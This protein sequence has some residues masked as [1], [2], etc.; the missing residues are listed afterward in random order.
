RAG[1]VRVLSA[2]ARLQGATCSSSVARTWG[3][4]PRGSSN[5]ARCGASERRGSQAGGWMTW[6]IGSLRERIEQGPRRSRPVMV[7]KGRAVY[8]ETPAK[9]REIHRQAV[10]DYFRPDF[11]FRPGITVLDGG[12]NIRTFSLEVL[13][14]CGGDERVLAVEPAPE[15]FATWSAT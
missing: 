13:Q 6:S 3:S 2:L 4:Q 12:A 10:D 15:P 8:G 1:R 14:R 11:Q 7:A 9:A 5:G